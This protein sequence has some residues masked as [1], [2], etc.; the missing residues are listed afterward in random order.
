MVTLKREDTVCE[1]TFP[2][3]RGLTEHLALIVKVSTKQHIQR[4]TNRL[5]DIY[6]QHCLAKTFGPKAPYHIG[7]T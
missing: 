6:A 7:G 4:F 1:F 5:G 2:S 3:H